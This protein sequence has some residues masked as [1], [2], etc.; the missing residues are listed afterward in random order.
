M[1]RLAFLAVAYNP[2][3]EAWQSAAQNYTMQAGDPP[4]ELIG[5]P[6]NPTTGAPLLGYT[7]GLI[8]SAHASR[9]TNDPNIA[10]WPGTTA[11]GP[12]DL[13]TQ[14][15]EL[16]ADDAA[17]LFNAARQM[18]VPV[19]LVSGES[20]YGEMFNALYSTQGLGSEL[21]ADLDLTE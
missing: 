19:H 18:G 15:L 10:F 1:K 20:T 7:I 8:P 13:D 12:A 14:I 5:I 3:Y 11:S 6:V 16:D 9:M 21:A 4:I 17:A 2:T